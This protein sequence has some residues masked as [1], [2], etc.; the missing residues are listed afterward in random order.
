MKVV[1]AL[2]RHETNTFSPLPTE[3]ASFN[4]GTG[5]NGPAY[6]DD[7][8]RACVNTN[9]AA[10]AYLDLADRLGAEV[11]FAIVA[12]A[13]PS[14]VVTADAF[15]AIV[16]SILASVKN[17]CDAVLLDLHGAMVAQGYPD[18]EGELLKRIRTILPESVPVIVALDFHA[19]FSR[20]LIDNATVI[21]G[22]CT[23]PHIDVYQ[24][25][26]RAGRTLQA[27]LKKEVEPVLLWRRLP[28]LTHM[29]RQTPALQPMKDIMD[30]A[31]AAEAQGE[32]LNASVFGGFPLADIP[33]VGLS[34][35]LVVD[36]KK[37]AQ[38]LRLLDELSELAWSR[39]DDFIFPLEPL[40]QSI[41]AAKRLAQGPIVL[42][43][44][45]DNCGAGGPTDVMEVLRE[46]MQQE[47]E[48]V[49]AGPIWD[50]AA[51]EL[52]IR[53]GVGARITL[54]LGGKTDMPALN[55]TGQPLRVTG[56]VAK[57]TDG[58]YRVTGP[59][60]TGMLLSLGRT[61]VLDT[62]KVLIFV[63]EKPQEPY[64]TGLF[65]HAGVDPASKKYVLIKSRQHFRA[66][67]GPL[68][69]HVV[70]VGGPGVCSSD[71]A[72][73]PFKH[74]QRPIYPLDDETQFSHS[75][76]IA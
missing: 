7:A 35:V 54:D 31:M 73:F 14:G 75:E 43:D 13:V 12:N 27:I 23:Y 30:R 69:K 3:L 37:R 63:S 1:I 68:A 21:T 22:Y 50:P 47:L 10:A 46:V 28:M 29:L 48:D 36:K 24:T 15:E 40:S 25:G 60:F 62:G 34:V 5:S 53:A 72:L 19:N 16:E 2:V 51:V 4:R 9:S 70:L 74:L 61:A 18:A 38:G 64:D 42:V 17:G 59:M 33:H 65:T 56:R 52:M 71:Y 39:R 57:I 6:A 76:S 41:A 67:F 8:R 58:N 55:L 49:V 66:G 32:V 11:D 44:H 45:G 20:D 26:E